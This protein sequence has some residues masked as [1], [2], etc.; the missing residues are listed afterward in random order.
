MLRNRT[1]MVG[2]ALLVGSLTYGATVQ[3]AARGGWQGTGIFVNAEDGILFKAKGRWSFG[4]CGAQCETGPIGQAKKGYHGY[5]RLTFLVPSSVN[6]ALVGR[7]G[8]STFYVGKKLKITAPES[9]EIMLAM[10][11]S[12]TS[13]NSGQLTVKI[14]IR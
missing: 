10:N 2:L 9:G 14:T 12:T 11:D 8:G 6:H 7:I 4:A 3:V 5:I 13:D 1:V